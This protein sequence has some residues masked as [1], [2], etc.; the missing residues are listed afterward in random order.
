MLALPLGNIMDPF[1]VIIQVTRI[2]I[3][4]SIAIFV[5]FICLTIPYFASKEIIE[6]ESLYH[7]VAILFPFIFGDVNNV[8]SCYNIFILI[9]S[10]FCGTIAG[11]QKISYSYNFAYDYISTMSWFMR[12]WHEPLDIF[13]KDIHYIG[14]CLNDKQHTQKKELNYYEPSLKDLYV[15]LKYV[16][17]VTCIFGYIEFFMENHRHQI[18]SSE[19]RIIAL[20]FMTLWKIIGFAVSFIYQKRYTDRARQRVFG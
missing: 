12:A 14:Q 9:T 11:I 10:C 2:I 16:T 1:K 7:D 19:E 8:L 13:K 6:N 15:T 3:E 5:C 4:V 18:K 17:V 20:S